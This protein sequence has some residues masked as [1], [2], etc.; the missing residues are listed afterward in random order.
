MNDKIPAYYAGYEAKA[1]AISEAGWIAAR[2]EFN[3]V[4]PPGKA[5]AGTPDELAFAQ[6]EYQAL[7]D[8]MDR[9]CA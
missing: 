6:G 1:A 7:C 4:N 8:T 3:R 5:W 2:D 9:R